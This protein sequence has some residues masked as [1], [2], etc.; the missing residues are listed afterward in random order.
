MTWNQ[1]GLIQLKSP[2]TEGRPGGL[3]LL[4]LCL[5]LA[6]VASFAF[7]ERPPR[8]WPG[9]ALNASDFVSGIPKVRDDLRLIVSVL[10]V[11]KSVLAENGKRILGFDLGTTRVSLS[12]PARIHY[13][14]DLSGAEPVEF[15]LNPER[16]EL[17]AVFPDPEVQAIELLAAK[18]QVAIEPGWGRLK[19]LSGRALQEGLERGLY[20]AVKADA[21]APA[22]V[23]QI[24]E[25][26]RPLLSRLLTDYLRR[27]DAFG[28][29]GVAVTRVR[30]KGDLDTEK[31]ALLTAVP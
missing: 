25:R 8:P 12:M 20:D 15:R 6:A 28:A 11:H 29:G 27:A 21:A 4:F 2:K 18:K 3:R 30:F 17:I 1:P 26:A 9:S 5:A 16:R 23:S 7:R 24:K 13:A 14:V 19:A 31:L 10:E 22:V